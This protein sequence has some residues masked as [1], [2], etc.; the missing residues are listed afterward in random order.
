MRRL[1]TLELLKVRNY[2]IFWVLT[3]FYVLGCVGFAWFLGSEE[4]NIG[5]ELSAESLG[6]YVFPKVYQS[7]AYI[8]GFFMIMLALVMLTFSVSE[9]QNRTFR[10]SVINGLSRTEFMLSKLYLI[11]FLCLVSTL[12]VV[13]TSF[14]L[15][16]IFTDNWEGVSMLENIEYI[17]A[18]FVQVFT[19]LMMGFMVGVL[20]RKTGVAIIIVAVYYLILER[21]ITLNVPESIARFFPAESIDNVIAFPLT[22]MVDQNF[23]PGVNM[24]NVLICLV[25]AG[26][27]SFVSYMTL[28]KRDI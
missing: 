10:Q 27:F 5:M 23:E 14:L 18:Y 16:F 28:N 13:L 12:T 24:M 15:G 22:E 17:I 9:F 21:V 11:V 4:I 6:V 25:W 26:I 8:F 3:S 1:L 19:F 2:P 20:V 7:V